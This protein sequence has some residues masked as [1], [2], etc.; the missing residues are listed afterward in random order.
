MFSLLW[1][2][3]AAYWYGTRSTTPVPFGGANPPAGVI[4]RRKTDGWKLTDVGRGRPRPKCDLWAGSAR[5]SD[6]I[7]GEVSFVEMDGSVK[8]SQCE[9]MKELT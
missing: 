4:L 6:E 9:G 1:S 2:K 7:Q 3:T 5:V 8:A